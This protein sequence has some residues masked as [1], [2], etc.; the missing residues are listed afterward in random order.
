MKSVTD[1]ETPSSADLEPRCLRYSFPLGTARIF[2][3]LLKTV[4]N[5]TFLFNCSTG[6]DSFYGKVQLLH[7]L[8][9]TVKA[10]GDWSVDEGI[11]RDNKQKGI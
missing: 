3:F 9:F 8:V 1:V 4:S 11:S 6:L 2:G 10:S 5:R 7:R